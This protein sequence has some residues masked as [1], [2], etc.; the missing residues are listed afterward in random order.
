MILSLTIRKIIWDWKLLYNLMSQ[1]MNQRA[2]I[3][4]EYYFFSFLQ[5]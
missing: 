1:L 2:Y 4:I 3:F 5:D